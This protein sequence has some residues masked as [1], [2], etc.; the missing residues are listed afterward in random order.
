MN[1]FN[2]IVALLVLVLSIPVL[3]FM[4]VMVAL[5]GPTISAL[6]GFLTNLTNLTLTVRMVV[7]A[8]GAVLILV[9]LGLIWMEVRPAPRQTVRVRQVEGGQAAISIESIAQSLTHNVSELAD[10]IRVNP[11]I[12]SRGKSVDVTLDVET[13]P[14]VNVPAKTAEVVN[15]VR[16]L[17][18]QRMGLTLHKTAVNIHI[19]PYSRQPSAAPPSP[20][21]L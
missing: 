12:T 8:V 5:P 2:R 6:Q 9:A 19:A 1:V 14:D 10:V 16:D 7:I 4:M 13:V 18:E 21:T 15:V 17:I 20:P 3:A 11:K